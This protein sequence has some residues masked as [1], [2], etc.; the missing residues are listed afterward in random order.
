MTDLNLL[1]T[2]LTW[3]LQSFLI[4]IGYLDQGIHKQQYI[5]P[6]IHLLHSIK[7]LT[8]KD[9][10]GWPPLCCLCF[11]RVWPPFSFFSSR[12]FTLLHLPLS[13]WS[14]RELSETSEWCAW[15]RDISAANLSYVL[16][17]EDLQ[18]LATYLIP[19]FALSPYSLFSDFLSFFSR[20]VNYC[21]ENLSYVIYT[22]GILLC[23]W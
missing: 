21:T 4:W 8:L 5:Y 6:S 12:W 10:E 18:L 23:S 17:D 3:W 9:V 11:T 14:Q 19:I 22:K 20:K 16:S 15:C 2:I 1:S 13:A 7:D